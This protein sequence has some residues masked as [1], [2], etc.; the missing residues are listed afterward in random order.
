MTKWPV[1]YR[2]RFTCR[3]DHKSHPV[4]RQGRQQAQDAPGLA[5]ANPTHFFP[6]LLSQ[7]S[8]RRAALL[9][10]FSLKVFPYPSP[11]SPLPQKCSTWKINSP[12][13][14][15]LLGF[16]HI[17]VTAL[18]TPYFPQTLSIYYSKALNR[19]WN[20]WKREIKQSPILKEIPVKQRGHSPT[21]NQKYERTTLAMPRTLRKTSGLP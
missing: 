14:V 20:E 17:S 15:L 4:L 18:L 21:G 1:C 5:R 11:S 6:G 8:Q 7:N 2:Q 12:F 16:V 3:P 9:S 19:P 10:T 13:L